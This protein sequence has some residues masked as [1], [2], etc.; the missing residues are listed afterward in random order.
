MTD[1]GYMDETNS[2]EVTEVPRCIMCGL[3]QEWMTFG[4]TE[5][6]D[7]HPIC[8]GWCQTWLEVDL[9]E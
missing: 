9:E 8:V 1:N 5:T 7:G 4:G 3:R 6:E 2:P